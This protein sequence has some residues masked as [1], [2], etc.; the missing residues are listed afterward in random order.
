LKSAG[1]AEVIILVTKNIEQKV[2]EYLLQEFKDGGLHLEAVDEDTDTAD[3]LRFIHKRIKVSY[4]FLF[5]ILGH[6][7]MLI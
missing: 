7:C 3:A 5:L 6:F 1:F 2:G 4:L